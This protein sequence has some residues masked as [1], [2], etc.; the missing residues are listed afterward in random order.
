MNDQIQEQKV[1]GDNKDDAFHASMKKQYSQKDIYFDLMDHASKLLR[2]GGILVF[3]FHTDDEYT[4]EENKFPE[5]E[6]FTFQRSSKDRLTKSRARHLI[7][8][9]KN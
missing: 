9:K 4:A 5:H 8:L 2:P 7:T 3:L 6:A 1:N